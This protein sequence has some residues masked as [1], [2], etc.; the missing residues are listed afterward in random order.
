[1]AWRRTIVCISLALLALAGPASARD[2]LILEAGGFRDSGSE[3][4]ELI[5]DALSQQGAFAGLAAQP[6]YGMSLDYLGIANAVTVNAT[7]F[8]STIELAIPST[9]FSRTFVGTSPDDVEEQV[10]DFFASESGGREL[11]KFLEETTERTALATLDGN[12][13]ATTALFARGAF[14]RFGLG[15]RRTR[16]GYRGERL[17]DWGHADLSLE[18]GGGAV[19]VDEFDSLYTAD[20]ALTLGGDFEPGLGLY[21]TAIGQL[22]SYDGAEIYDAGLELAVPISLLR[23]GAGSA[24]HWTLTPFA[25]AGGGLSIDLISGGFLVGGGGVSALALQLGPVE[26]AV[27]NELAYYGGVPLGEVE[28]VEVDTRL[29]QLV[30]RN[31]GKLALHPERLRWISAEVGVSFTSFLFSDAAV[32]FYTTPFAGVA[33]HPFGEILR[34]RLGWESDLGADYAAHLGRVELGLAF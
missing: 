12:P 26:L 19:D 13:R 5:E 7:L 9:G 25:Q 15:A 6:A 18:V 24:L 14:D 31:G 33:L 8:G 23:P 4:P 17:A 29:D 11:A 32:D 27:A 3:L 2:L 16:A 22:R 28:G 30:T 20:A 1:M 10:E 21:A 34:L